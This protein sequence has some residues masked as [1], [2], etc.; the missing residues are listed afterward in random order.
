MDLTCRARD[1]DDLLVMPPFM[2]RE[3]PGPGVVSLADNLLSTELKGHAAIHA[4]HTVCPLMSPPRP[5]PGEK[6]GFGHWSNDLFAN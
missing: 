5:H 1:P 2:G 3:A 6:A 4:G